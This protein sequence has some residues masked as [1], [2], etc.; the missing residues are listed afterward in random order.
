MD[1]FELIRRYFDHAGAAPGVVRG[2][3]DDGAVLTPSPGMEQ[4]QV[5]DTLVEG[6]HFPPGFGPSDIGYRV[7]AVNVSDLA[8]MG[9]APR[10]ITLAL[11]LPEANNEWLEAFASGLFA[12]CE[13]YG[14]TLVGGD[15]TAAPVLVITVCATG[16]VMPGQALLRS[17]ARPGDG[18]YVTG[19]LGDAA[20][21][22]QGLESGAP[23]RELVWRF[24]RP[25]ARPDYG[26]R[27]AGRASA[28]IDISD[29]LAGDLGKL[30]AASGTGADMAL[31]ELPLS[32]AM[33]ENFE[34]EQQREFALFGGDDYELLFTCRSEPPD[35]GVVPVT[36]IGEVSDAPGVR[37]TLAGDRVPIDGGGYHHFQ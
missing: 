10:W 28:A 17:G 9:S 14:V 11:S 30:M 36:R 4:V 31:G 21:G 32:S 13:Q 22:L 8:A 16:E 18:I 29:G 19:T 1:E 20:A 15:T 23:V 25:A 33:R 35:A 24:A 37:W 5:I 6:V 26:C 2:I 7:V 27:L 34:L 3:G 12:A